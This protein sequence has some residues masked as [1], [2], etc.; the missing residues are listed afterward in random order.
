ML[1]TVS[2]IQILATIDAIDEL[3][4]RGKGGKDKVG[5]CEPRLTPLVLAVAHNVQ[6]LPTFK[7][8]RQVALPVTN[9][10]RSIAVS[11]MV[12]LMPSPCYISPRSSTS[13]K[14]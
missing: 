6:S 8:G 12:P 13:Q 7:I 11:Y 14:P 4:T 9:G 3:E 2:A 1:Y 5:T 10:E